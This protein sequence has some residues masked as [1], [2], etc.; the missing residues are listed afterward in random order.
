MCFSSH[1]D[2]FPRLAPK[3]YLQ[4]LT[5]E[6]ESGTGIEVNED[7]SLHF[8][9]PEKRLPLLTCIKHQRLAMAL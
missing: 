6:L 4:C 8:A 9:S 7:M 3:L 5:K 2:G 1:L